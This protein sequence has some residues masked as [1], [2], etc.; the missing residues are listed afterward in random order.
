[1]HKSSSQALPN[2]YVGLRLTNKPAI[3]GHFSRQPVISEPIFRSN[4]KAKPLFP[5]WT[6]IVLNNTSI[7]DK[8]HENNIVC[9]RTPKTENLCVIKPKKKH[10]DAKSLSEF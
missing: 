4:M 6:H 10:S 9:G 3:G 5:T 2:F 1:M 7:S 8:R